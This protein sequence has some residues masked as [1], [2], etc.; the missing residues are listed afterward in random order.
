MSARKIMSLVLTAALPLSVWAVPVETDATGKDQEAALKKA[1]V[2]AVRNVMLTIT[3]EEFVRGHVSDIR[4]QI[5]LNSG[6]LVTGSEILSSE[7]NDKG[8]TKVRARFE[9]DRDKIAGIISKIGGGSAETPVTAD[10]GNTESP[11]TTDTAST[12][13]TEPPKPETATNDTQKTETAGT[14]TPASG[15]EVTPAPTP[16]ADPRVAE[17]WLVTKIARD[18]HDGL[19]AVGDEVAVREVSR[20]TA[21]NGEEITQYEIAELDPEVEDSSADSS[22]KIFEFITTRAPEGVTAKLNISD[23][24]YEAMDI[25]DVQRDTVKNILSGTK[26][27]YSIADDSLKVTTSLKEDS[28]TADDITVKWAPA[29]METTMHNLTAY[30]DSLDYSIS[31]PS[32]EILETEEADEE[33]DGAAEE[34]KESSKKDVLLFGLSNFSLTAQNRLDGFKTDLAAG[35]VSYSPLEI[36]DVKTGF[37][38]KI[39]AAA[40]KNSLSYSFKMA[41]LVFAEPDAGENERF[42]V[43]NASL[44][45][46]LNNLDTTAMAAAC[47][48][49][50]AGMNMLQFSKCNMTIDDDAR[51]AAFLGLLGWDFSAN[52]NLSAQLGGSQVSAKATAGIKPQEKSSESADGAAPSLPNIPGDIILDADI[53]IDAA[54]LGKPQYI[55]EDVTAML[56]Q[57]AQDPAATVYTYHLE[58]RDGALKINGK[59]MQ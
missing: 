43:K 54:L 2:N 46:S 1:E 42:D 26:G 21:D 7:S 47:G 40:H 31:I 52:I 35:K 38:S 14:V 51:E 30:K 55:P 48:D 57:Y 34:K 6:E 10:T 32:L 53:S 17:R 22:R 44:D 56:K 49:K 58:F 37:S 13:N 20:K 28:R 19:T 15:P 27:F 50:T 18:I 59:D 29:V 45:L 23:A 24:L 33:A 25:E 8:Q 36:T 41:Q 39:D 16:G 9:V 4:Q 3:D 11:S 5:I 12:G